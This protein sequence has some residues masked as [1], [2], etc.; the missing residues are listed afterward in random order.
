MTKRTKLQAIL[1]E[2]CPKCR[3]GNIFAASKWSWTKFTDTHKNCPNCKVRFAPEPDFYQGAMY[4]SY[5]FTVFW[6]A[7]VTVVLYL[8]LGFVEVWT[9]LIVITIVLFLTAR[10]NFRYARVLMLY[11]FAGLKY[12]SEDLSITEKIKN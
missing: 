7:L 5:G 6:M 12:E 8:F 9:Y 1:Q 2:K 10:M 3:E 11:W 4:I